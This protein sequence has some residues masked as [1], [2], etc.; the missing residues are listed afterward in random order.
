[1]STKFV[2]GCLAVAV[3][4]WLV[5]K[6]DA[7]LVVRSKPGQPAW[8]VEQNQFKNIAHAQWVLRKTRTTRNYKWI[9]EIRSWHSQSIVW[10]RE[11]HDRL[12]YRFISPWMQTY[13]C[14]HGRGGW[15]TNT[16]NGFYGGLQ[17]DYGTWLSNGGGRFASHAHK[18]TPI[19]QVTVASRL[20]YDG[21][22]NCPNP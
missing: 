17:F 3:L 4:F 8:K 2:V 13:N 12:M 7:H 16:G 11:S 14:E 5:P 9:R 1:M 19:Q 10:L 6:S 15:Y 18:A 20:T 21:W 22:P